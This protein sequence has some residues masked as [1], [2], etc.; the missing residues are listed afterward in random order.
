MQRPLSP[1]LLIDDRHPSKLKYIRISLLFTSP[2]EVRSERI[3]IAADSLQI[4]ARHT[5]D[6]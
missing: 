3:P 4:L 2:N 1:D 6:G 5:H